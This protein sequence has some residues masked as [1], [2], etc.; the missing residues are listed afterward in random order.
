[1]EMVLVLGMML[2]MIDGDD[3]GDDLPFQEVFSSAESTHQRWL[4][5]SVG[6][7]H[8]AAAKLC[9]SYIFR[10]FTPGG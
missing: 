9:V 8:E 4:F 7:R 5:F 6:F 3:D 10:V 2:M 1:M